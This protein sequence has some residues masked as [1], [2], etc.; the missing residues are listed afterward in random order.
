MKNLLSLGLILILI[1]TSFAGCKKDKGDPP[2]LPP[3]ESMTIDFSNFQVQKKG[4]AK[5]TENSAWEFSATVAGIWRLIINT[6]LIVPV[7]SFQLA[8]NQTPVYLAKNNWQW[9]Y[10]VTVAGSAYKARL[11]GEIRTSDVAWK[12]YVTKE[13]TGAFAEFLWFEGTSKLDGTGG[14]WILNQ[15]SA[16][17][18]PFLQ[19]DWTKTASAIGKITYTYVKNGDPLKTSYIEYGLTS[20]TLNAY[21]KV[22][23][24]NGV[25]FSD[26]DVEWSTTL[27]NGRVKS[28]D[29]F[30]G[31]TNWHCWDA[32]KVNIT[33]P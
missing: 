25:K 30:L 23:Y 12:M 27:K 5:G 21:Y 16:A 18:S 26:V 22:R 2:V 29:Y 6:T 32:N 28:I 10:N 9:S 8:V 15:S 7:T 4:D 3:A 24:Y 31:D 14:Q 17:P 1:A 20:N 13:G 33:C 11:T 19:I